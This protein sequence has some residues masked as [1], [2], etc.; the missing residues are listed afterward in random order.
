MREVGELVSAILGPDESLPR[1]VKLLQPIPE[2]NA[3]VGA[4][5]ARVNGSMFWSRVGGETGLLSNAV[6]RGLAANELVEDN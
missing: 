2:L 6:A 5:F 3:P 1:R 4:V